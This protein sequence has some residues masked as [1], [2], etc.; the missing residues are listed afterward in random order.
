M[1]CPADGKPCC[2]DLCNSG[3]CLCMPGY[4]PLR[5]CDGCGGIIDTT[6]PEC[7]TCTCDPD[8]D[9]WY[10]DSSMTETAK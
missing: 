3:D 4:E 1:I 2:D 6:I 9:Y 8:E 5:R 7:S 10:D